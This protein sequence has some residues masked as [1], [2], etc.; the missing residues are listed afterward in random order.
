MSCQNWLLRCAICS[1]PVTLEE[2][3]TDERGLAVHE[4][5]Y[6]WTV[7]LKKP[8]KRVNQVDMVPQLSLAMSRELS[9]QRENGPWLLA[10]N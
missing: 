8:R 7:A 4:N 9:R 3:K 1:K 2:S 10:K 5:C 6:V